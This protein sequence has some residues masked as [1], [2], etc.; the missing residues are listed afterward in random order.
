MEQFWKGWDE[1]KVQENVQRTCEEELWCEVRVVVHRSNNQS[2]GNASAKRTTTTTTTTTTTRRSEDS[3]AEVTF[4]D[5]DATPESRNVLEGLGADDR[6]AW[7][8]EDDESNGVFEAEPAERTRNQ[9]AA[10]QHDLVLTISK[11][12]M[13]YE[14]ALHLMNLFGA[15]GQFEAANRRQQRDCPAHFDYIDLEGIRCFKRDFKHACECAG[16]VFDCFKF[17]IFDSAPNRGRTAASSSWVPPFPPLDSWVTRRP[18]PTGWATPLPPPLPWE[19]SIAEPSAPSDPPTAPDWVPLFLPSLLL[20]W[21]P[22]TS[23]ASWVL[24]PPMRRNTTST[25]TG[26]FAFNVDV[27]V[28]KDTGDGVPAK[29]FGPPIQSFLPKMCGGICVCENVVSLRRCGGGNRCGFN[30]HGPDMR[31]WCIN[32]FFFFLVHTSTWKPPSKV[33]LELVEGANDIAPWLPLLVYPD[34]TSR[35]YYRRS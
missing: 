19:P 15:V 11:V 8:S 1:K 10:L 2:I 6:G 35:K 24:V 14:G 23:A 5:A 30:E 21:N 13:P 31:H 26:V 7:L 16:E 18:L 17:K 4:S 22:P 25:T 29:V 34:S 33:H 28:E 3:V 9:D 32:C 27:E 12:R 20:P